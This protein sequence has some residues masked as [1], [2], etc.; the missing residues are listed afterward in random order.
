MQSAF[1][2]PSD[3]WHQHWFD[4]DYLQLYAHR[5]EREAECL[6]EQLRHE[7]GLLPLRA[8]GSP[9]RVLD[10]GCGAGRHSRM[11]ARA[12]FRVAGLDRSAEL[13]AEAARTGSPEAGPGPL[14]LRGDLEAL[15]F[16]GHFDWVL[17][18]FTS[19]GYAPEDAVNERIF[20]GLLEMVAPQG[21][22]VLDY[23][24]PA[25][26]R[27]TLVPESR[28][29]VGDWDVVER[30]H[31]DPAR[32][33]VVKEIHFGPGDAAPRRVVEAVKL[34]EPAWFLER[35]PGFT[36]RAHLGSVDGR[37]WK[38]DSERSLLLLERGKR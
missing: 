1:P 5:D 23:L 19:F 32:N 7:Y 9:A 38:T 22:L 16:R 12:G 30:R 18:L 11:L 21:R 4:N 15:P 29:R 31:L 26:L 33:M 37:P 14:F 20:R 3:R 6:L 10:A 35:S 28:R 17:S 24:N 34:Y 13:L 2:A 27:A 8:D 36:L 25:H